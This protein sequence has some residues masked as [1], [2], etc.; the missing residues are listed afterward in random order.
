[1][2]TIPETSTPQE[3]FDFVVN[4]LYTQGQ[5]AMAGITNDL[6]WCTYRSPKGLTCAVG[7]LLTDQEYKPDFEKRGIWAL[8]KGE[9]E[10]GIPTLVNEAGG[11]YARHVSL[12]MSLQDVHDQTSRPAGKYNLE[13]LAE[14]FKRVAIK[15][16]L[17]FKEPA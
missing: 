15:Y 10:A 7:C 17:T 3:V 1:M 13:D 9:V 8:A 2:P 12:L 5:P 6:D 4:H 16:N 14:A 11:F